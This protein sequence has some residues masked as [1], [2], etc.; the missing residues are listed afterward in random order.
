MPPIVD[1]KQKYKPDISAGALPYAMLIKPGGEENCWQ[2]E[3]IESSMLLL[4]I[5]IAED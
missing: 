5:R 1:A 2:E 3:R 4:E